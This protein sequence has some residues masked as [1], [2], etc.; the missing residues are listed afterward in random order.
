VREP[1][2]RKLDYRR[3]GG[4]ARST[5]PW[6]GLL[7]AG[8]VLAGVGFSPPVI[9][10]VVWAVL[11]ARRVVPSAA[12]SES[13]TGLVAVSLMV[14]PAAAFAAVVLGGGGYRRRRDRRFL[15]V[16]V[17]GAVALVASC[18]G[19]WWMMYVAAGYR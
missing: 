18:G 15:A 13:L 9:G 1:V 12:V 11:R 2:V 16:Q 3:P 7:R 8:F 4:E 14:G 17:L 5:S 19:G 10:V 6:P